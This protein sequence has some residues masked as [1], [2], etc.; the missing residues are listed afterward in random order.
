[1]RKKELIFSVTIKDCEVN[2]FRSGG[3]GGQ[4]Q[5]KT[6]SAVRVIH[7]PSGA[8]GES[9]EMKSQYANKQRA[10]KRMAES[11]RFQRWVRIELARRVGQP[12]VEKQV[13]QALSPTNLR[14]EVHDDKK[15]W[16]EN[17]ELLPTEKEIENLFES[18]E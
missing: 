4:H 11:D 17:K 8:I 16:I 3:P 2:T 14:L 18:H 10:F 13:K 7:R 9:R 6:E 1:M 15:R 12:S 5:N